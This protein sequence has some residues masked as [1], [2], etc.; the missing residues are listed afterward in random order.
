M[1]ISH[2]KG[3]DMI[4][5]NTRKRITAYRF[6][7]FDLNRVAVTDAYSENAF[8]KETEYLLSLEPDKLLA[9]FYEMQG[10][11]GKAQKY[12]GWESTEIKGHTLGH[13]L[14]AIAQAYLSSGNEEFLRRM[15]YMTEEL[16]RCQSEEGYLFASEEEIFDR[17]ENR[18]P[19]WVPWYTMHK[20]LS[21]LVV[22]CRATANPETLTVAS[23]LGDWIH[24]RT[25]RWSKE[26]QSLVLSVEYG[27][28]N[29]AL[30]E[31]YQ[32]TGKK[33]HLEAAHMFDELPLFT[34][35]K[36]KRDILDGKH[37][38]TTI[39]KM[40]GALN[41]YV[42]LGQGEEFY[43]EAAENFWDIVTSHHTYI[44]GGN[45]EWEHFG[46][47]DQLDSE[48]TN[49]NCETCNSY[50]MLKLS[51]LLFLV[52]GK[53]K[54]ADFYEAAQVNAILASQN[55]NTG[56][57]TYFQ[58]M[59]T[60]YFKVY[61][62]PFDKF[63]CCTGT[64][65]ENFTKLGD[66]I[67]NHSEDTLVINRY[68][69][70]KLDWPEKGL[71]LRQETDIPGDNKVNII[72]EVSEDCSGEKLRLAL[73]IPDWCMGEPVVR[74]NHKKVKPITEDGYLI[75]NRSWHNEDIVEMELPIQVTY[76]FLPDNPAVVAFSYGPAVLCAALGTEQMN[77]VQ[78][79]V[80]VDIPV[81]ESEIKDYII[82]KEGNTCDWLRDLPNHLVRTGEALEF[83]L[84]G[85]DEDNHLV[86]TPYYRQHSQRYGIYWGLFGADSAE[87]SRRIREENEKR[88]FEQSIID[89]IPIGNDQYELVHQVKGEHTEAGG[90]EGHRCRVLREHG[91]CS[92]RMKVVP[93]KEYYLGV[94]Y[95]NQDIGKVFH[96]YIDG[97][98]V[99]TDT[100]KD[101][102][103][104]RFFPVE[105][106]VPHRYLTGK[107]E[108]EIRY[109]HGDPITVNSIWDLLYLRKGYEE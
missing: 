85:T 87:L 89:K 51:R 44:T 16:A 10:K 75:L 95:F 46:T 3:T 33:E 79:G 29:D 24:N 26:L 48:R 97:E 76:S 43:L 82:I 14:T 90:I 52:T 32:L 108:I 13:Y 56:M 45:S 68:I 25:S 1:T 54:Y 37:A 107:E 83:T 23:K 109:E 42:V 93:A 15:N 80:A 61:G 92:Y 73:R 27:G 39:P 36:E 12:S 8:R 35:M 84:K 64:G 70:S 55:P 88:L 81:K 99:I 5:N 58:P 31:L 11:Q 2:K 104:K 78:T 67:Y 57:S 74:I 106:K 19:A 4:K 18:K 6:H 103:G 66:A 96:I 65:M 50:N 40:I 86:F 22:V 9:G 91:W 59:A 105:Y 49:C 7:A 34:A 71:V 102:S 53:K 21:G 60:G 20:I 98:P 100:L 28:M 62:T 63:W 69:S 77:I 38:N 101:N 41:R 72:V 17:V 47:P 30:Y 94:T